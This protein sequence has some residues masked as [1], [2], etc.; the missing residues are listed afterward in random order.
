MHAS[1]YHIPI[2]FF[3]VKHIWWLHQKWYDLLLRF[4]VM[5]L[6][7]LNVCWSCLSTK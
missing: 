6:Y 4:L 5:W 2:N 7:T 1:I 3:Q